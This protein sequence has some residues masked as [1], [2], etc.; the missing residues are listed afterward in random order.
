MS[1]IAIS[2]KVVPE[3]PEVDFDTI[4]NEIKDEFET[5]D[6]KEEA[7]GFGLKS[8]KVLILKDSD[9]GGTDDI[10]NYISDIDNVKS[11]EIESVN[12]L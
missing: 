7:I 9:S 2:V 12:K 8:L 6:I 4:A 11:V 3:S 10:E 5:K 1:K